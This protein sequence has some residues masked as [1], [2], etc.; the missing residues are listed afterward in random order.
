M[1][2]QAQD[3]NLPASSRKI[4]KARGE[5]QVARSRELGHLTAF[6]V[7]GA[8]I[9]AFGPELVTWLRVLVETGRRFDARSLAPADA[10]SLHLSDLSLRMLWLVL[11]M[12]FLRAAAAVAV[13][14]G[15]WAMNM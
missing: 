5:G 2:D 4:N 13:V 7:G 15:A 8:L 3:R 6:A 14:T 9:V 10:M 1:A 12:G 11:P